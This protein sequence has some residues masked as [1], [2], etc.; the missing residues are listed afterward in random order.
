MYTDDS[1]NHFTIIILYAPLNTIYLLG[2]FTFF[3]PP[4]AN[5]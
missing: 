1:L 2:G 5:P 3:T 4:V